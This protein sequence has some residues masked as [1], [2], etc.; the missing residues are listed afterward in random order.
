MKGAPTYIG[1]IGVPHGVP[2]E[3]KLADQIAGGFESIFL[4]ITPNKTIDWISYI[5]YIITFDC[6]P[7]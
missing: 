1:A 5:L 4:W 6:K 2:D 3:F 7:I